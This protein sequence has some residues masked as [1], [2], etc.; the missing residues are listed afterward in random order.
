MPN[1]GFAM[2]GAQTSPLGTSRILRI[3][4]GYEKMQ[5]MRTGISKVGRILFQLRRAYGRLF[6]AG[7]ILDKGRC[8]HYRFS[9]IHPNRDF[10]LLEYL[11]TQKHGRFGFDKPAGASI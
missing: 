10:G 2:P 1:Y 4:H 6:P 3:N 11:L 7:G 9:D 5:K 8:E